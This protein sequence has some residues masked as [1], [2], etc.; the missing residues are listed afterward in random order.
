MNTL[1]TS[2]G[3]ALLVLSGR[4]RPAKVVAAIPAAPNPINT[5][6]IRKENKGKDVNINLVPVGGHGVWRQSLPESRSSD[7]GNDNDISKQAFNDG[8]KGTSKAAPWSNVLSQMNETKAENSAA[9]QVVRN[10][11]DIEDEDEEEEDMSTADQMRQIQPL[12]TTL[13]PVAFGSNQTSAPTNLNLPQTLSQPQPADTW[14]R[15]HQQRDPA[16]IFGNNAPTNSSATGSWRSSDLKAQAYQAPTER[17]AAP[18]RNETIAFGDDRA[19]G[20]SRKPWLG[21]DRYEDGRDGGGR[22]GFA[23]WGRDRDESSQVWMNTAHYLPCIINE[24][25]LS[26]P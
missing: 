11:A 9:Q 17:Y 6:S 25:R 2:R 24:Q 13:Q 21:G 22:G 5:P 16:R 4:T 12:P 20:D 1:G 8:S 7:P 23:R 19:G 15:N 10:W 14:E 26:I 18:F 3:G